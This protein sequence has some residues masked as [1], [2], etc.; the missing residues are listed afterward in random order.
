MSMKKLKALKTY[1]VISSDGIECVITEFDTEDQML[2]WRVTE[3][4]SSCP[5]LEQISHTEFIDN[6]SK[7]RFNLR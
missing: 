6:E 2:R 3:N 5:W 1:N 4:Y 7:V